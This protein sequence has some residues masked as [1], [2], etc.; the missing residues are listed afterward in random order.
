VDRTTVDAFVDGAGVLLVPP[1]LI[2]GARAVAV[3]AGMV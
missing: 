1:T 2:V 3:F